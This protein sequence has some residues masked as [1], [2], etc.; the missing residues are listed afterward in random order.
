MS[1][2]DLRDAPRILTEVLRHLTS[3][4]QSEMRLARAHANE[5]SAK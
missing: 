5:L 3:L 4:V 1:G 2:P